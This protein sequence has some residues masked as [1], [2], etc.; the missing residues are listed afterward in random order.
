MN[1]KITAQNQRKDG[2]SDRN[3]QT[4]P[5]EKTATKAAPEPSDNDSTN[6][7]MKPRMSRVTAQPIL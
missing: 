5:T 3:S 4:T 1:G 2:K 7:F 6:V